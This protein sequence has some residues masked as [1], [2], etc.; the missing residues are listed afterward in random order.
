LANLSAAS[1]M[2]LLRSPSIV[3]VTLWAILLKNEPIDVAVAEGPMELVAVGTRLW[4][5]VEVLS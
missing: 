3:L 2:T 5:S 1:P 4:P